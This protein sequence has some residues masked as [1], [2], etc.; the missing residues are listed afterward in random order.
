MATVALK[1]SNPAYI[2][3]AGIPDGF[4]PGNGS[5]AP[6]N[7]THRLPVGLWWSSQTADQTFDMSRPDTRAFVYKCVLQNGMSHEVTK[8]IRPEALLEAWPQMFVTWAVA[9]LWQPWIDAHS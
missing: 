4:E 9:Q 3:A 2:R 1:P 8:W 7:G 6:I 5:T